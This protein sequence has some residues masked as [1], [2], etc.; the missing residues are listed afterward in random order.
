MRRLILWVPLLVFA[1]FGTVFAVK[2]YFVPDRVIQSAM[3]GQP[4]PAFDLPP[5]LPGR[6]GLS[7]TPSGDGR[8]RLINIFASW[9]LPCRVEA[10]QLAELQRRGVPIDGIAVRDRPQDVAAGSSSPWARPGCPR[11]SSSIPPESSAT[12]ISA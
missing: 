6:P 4:L 2:L 12:S 10:P 11:P 8:P 3:I 1:L 7:S 5:S 9:C